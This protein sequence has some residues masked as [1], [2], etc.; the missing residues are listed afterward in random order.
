MTNLPIYIQIYEQLKNE[1]AAGSYVEGNLLP[2]E[3]ELCEK[4]NST[5]MTVR[6]ALQELV[7]DGYIHR[8][9]GKGSIVSSTRRSLGLLSI[10]G[11][12]D[13]VAGSKKHGT[14]AILEEMTIRQL[15]GPMFSHLL[16]KEDEAADFYYL[17]RLRSVDKE[18]IMVEET[19]IPRSQ[20]IDL[21]TEPLTEGSLFKTLYTRY[22]T[23][24][25]DMVQEIR[26]VTCNQHTAAL[27]DIPKQTPVLHI[28]RRY[29]TSRNG[30]Y[31]YSS[32]HCDTNKFAISGFN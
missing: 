10:K 3:N 28:L 19:F 7:Q 5:R 12:T 20:I 16:I 26:A 31:L 1:I 4:Y 18:P 13:V 6:R 15:N 27:L 22:N 11:W 25:T 32:I 14:T 21:D 8:K 17:K 9:Q 2:S 24:V 29:S 23:D 30:C